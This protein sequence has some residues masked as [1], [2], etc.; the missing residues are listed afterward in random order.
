MIGITLRLT[1]T[2][3]SRS[4]PASA[5]ASRKSEICSACSSSNGTPVSSSSSVEL[6]RFM[7][8]SAVHGALSRLPEPHQ[9]RSGSPGDCGW[10]GSQPRR[11]ATAR[12]GVHDARAGDRRAEQLGL[13][14]ASSASVVPSGGT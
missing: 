6:I 2:R 8:C 13:A 4:C 3:G 12:V 9:I 14:R 1:D 5:H 11:R 10:I 7:P